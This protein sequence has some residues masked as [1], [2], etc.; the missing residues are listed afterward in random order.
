M[1]GLKTGNAVGGAG[2]GY[3]PFAGQLAIFRYYNR[4]LTAQEIA[5][6]YS[7]IVPE[8]AMLSLLGLGAL[9]LLRRRRT[10]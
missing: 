1:V 9:G 8:P 4:A 2:T 3:G 6:N 7:V 5:R 10:R